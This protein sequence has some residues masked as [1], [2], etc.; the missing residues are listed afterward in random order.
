MSKE[1]ILRDAM[2]Y[3]N[4]TFP[5][6]GHWDF[7]PPVMRAMVDF[8]DQE[9]AALKEKINELTMDN[10][11]HEYN[12]AEAEKF[13]PEY[14]RQIRED[15]KNKLSESLKPIIANMR[16]AADA[17]GVGAF[18]SFADEIEKLINDEQEEKGCKKQAN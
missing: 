1:E 3:Y 5:N 18:N 17:W 6:V 11:T 7:Y 8:A 4:I 12:Q 14:E 16:T 2:K 13:A 10:M 9:T 15:E